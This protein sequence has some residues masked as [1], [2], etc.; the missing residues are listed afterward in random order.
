MKILGVIP[1]RY[2]SSRFP[3]K[4]LVD[5]KG[6]PM[7]Q[8]VY[9]RAMQA[10]L[11][12]EV[13]VA[14]DDKR[15]YD[16]VKG[17]GG[18]V[19]MTS[20]S[21]ENGTDRCREVV[22]KHLPE[23]DVVINIQGDEPYVHPEQIDKLCSLFESEAVTLG[24]LAKQTHAADD[25]LNPSRVKVVVDK[26]MDAL[27]FSRSPIPFFRGEEKNEWGNHHTYFKHLGLYGYRKEALLK[28]NQL[29][30]SELE[31]AEALEQLKWLENGF[32]MR[33]GITEHN[34]YAIDTPEDLEDL[35]KMDV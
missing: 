1:A 26:S 9:E 8:H 14:T 18:K 34:S 27:Y 4:P 17:F 13:I 23:Y 29:K 15:I 6:K 31:K 7:V 25:I 12:A 24:T 32:K 5:I 10:K 33:V 19:V 3:G 22:E 28:Y 35:L 2:A 30:P 16:T 20:E 11:L 21:C